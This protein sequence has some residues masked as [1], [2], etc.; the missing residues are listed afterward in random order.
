LIQLAAW[1]G[2]GGHRV[3]WWLARSD[4][5]AL[6]DRSAGQ[7]PRGS[8]DPPRHPGQRSTVRTKIN[9]LKTQVPPGSCFVHVTSLT[10]PPDLCGS[11]QP[12][13]ASH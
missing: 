12:L 9:T 13:T 1:S 8:R 3:A 5:G 10:S 7:V 2:A 4:L 11:T 6:R